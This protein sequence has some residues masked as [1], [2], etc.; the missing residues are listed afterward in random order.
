MEDDVITVIRTQGMANRFK[1]YMSILSEHDEVNTEVFAD[2]YLFPSIAY[3]ENPINK[4]CG[5]RLKVLPEEEDYIEKYKTIDLLYQDTPSYFIEK[6]LKVLDKIE[7]NPEVLDYVNSFLDD[8]SNVIGLHIRSWWHTAPPRIYWHDN[9]L[10][11]DEIDKLDST[12][13]I[14]LCS[15]NDDVIRYFKQKYGQRIIA[16]EQIMHQQKCNVFGF[17]HDDI[18][19]VVDGFIDC[20]LLSKCDTIIGTWAS[21]FTEVAWW[22][23]KCKSN[24]I[25]PKSPNV[26]PEDEKDFFILK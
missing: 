9:K 13:S 14:F 15:D 25:I 4:Q 24:V 2:N 18:Q 10:F 3:N 23:G 21:T 17:H 11:E 12:K 26:T 20:L 8:W 5:W 19:L 16:H 22:L 7:I 6:Y 1:T